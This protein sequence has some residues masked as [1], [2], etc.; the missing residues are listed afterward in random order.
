MGESSGRP[1]FCA[2]RKMK[3]THFIS[4]K[5]L[6]LCNRRKLLGRSARSN[7]PEPPLHPVDNRL[8]N[9][10]GIALGQLRRFPI[11]GSFRSPAQFIEDRNHDLFAYTGAAR[12]LDEMPGRNRPYDVVPIVPNRHCQAELVMANLFGIDTRLRGDHIVPWRHVVTAAGQQKDAEVLGMPIR[13]AQQPER[14]RRFEEGPLIL[15]GVSLPRSS[16]RGVP[17]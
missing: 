17:V 11:N 3:A 5:K 6:T 9:F 12:C 8:G 4:T 13:C 2:S 1:A 16:W 15:C 7:C 10:H 14:N